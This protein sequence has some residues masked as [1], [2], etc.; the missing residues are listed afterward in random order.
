[1]CDDQGGPSPFEVFISG[2]YPPTLSPLERVG[3]ASGFITHI[4]RL[5]CLAEA[6]PDY[7]LTSDESA[8]ETHYLFSLSLSV[9][10]LGSFALL[11]EPTLS[12]SIYGFLDNVF[13]H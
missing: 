9:V 12:P 1:M 2:G 3:G 7:H 13:I 8:I 5:I 11:H 4:A 10:L 6:R